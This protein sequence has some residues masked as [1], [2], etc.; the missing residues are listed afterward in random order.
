M[1]PVLI[2]LWHK[3]WDIPNALFIIKK[4]DDL[5]KDMYTQDSYSWDKRFIVDG[6]FWVNN[7]FYIWRSSLFAQRTSLVM[8]KTTKKR[9]DNGKKSKYN[10]N[11]DDVWNSLNT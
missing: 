4:G 9:N 1:Q 2:L 3:N 11:D 10:G 5:R 7:W 8:T 6:F